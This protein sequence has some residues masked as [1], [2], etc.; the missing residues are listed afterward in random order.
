MFWSCRN[1]EIYALFIEVAIVKK[2]YALSIDF[3]FSN[4]LKKPKHTV[5]LFY[6]CL[7]NL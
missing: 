1:V 7:D 3:G 6:L 2:Y 5:L 4:G